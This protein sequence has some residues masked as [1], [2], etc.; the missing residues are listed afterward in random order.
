MSLMGK[1]FGTSP[2]RP[3][4]EHMRA[5]AACARAVLP[6]F[7]DMAAGKSGELS[8]HRDEINHLEHEADRIK[9][10]IRSQLPRRMMLPVERRDLLEILDCQDTMADLAQDIAGLVDQRRMTIPPGLEEPLLDLVRRVISACEKARSIIEELDELIETGFSG[11]EVAVV[12]EKI[13][14]LSLIESD[15]DRM[16]ERIQRS[17]FEREAELGVGTVFWY[18]LV[19]WIAGMA[20]EAERVGNRLRLLI[21]S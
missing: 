5:A 9:H 11:R 10:E 13:T 12:E 20:D 2:I 17:L 19:N 6:L 14:D 15:T 3:M 4:Q 21:A 16:A 7:E 1:L 18:D 8:R